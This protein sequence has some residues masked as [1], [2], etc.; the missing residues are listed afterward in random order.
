MCVC[1]RA[2]AQDMRQQHEDMAER[3]FISYKA[4]QVVK[5][6]RTCG[7]GLEKV[8]GCDHVMCAPVTEQPLDHSIPPGLLVF[9]DCVTTT[10]RHT[11]CNYPAGGQ[12]NIC[13]RYPQGPSAA[14]EPHLKANMVAV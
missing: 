8:D 10:A 14:L 9:P 5:L 12:H 11:K 7:H 2:R 1:V 6:C 4:V 13:H 3:H